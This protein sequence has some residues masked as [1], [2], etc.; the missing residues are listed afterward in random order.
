MGLIWGLVWVHFSLSSY[1]GSSVFWVEISGIGDDWLGF[2][3]VGL[4]E[5]DLSFFF[6]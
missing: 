1:D 6:A 2:S 3:R 4:W 5:F